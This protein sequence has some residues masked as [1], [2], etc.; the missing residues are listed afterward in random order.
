MEISDSQATSIALSFLLKIRFDSVFLVTLVILK[1]S[2]R[3]EMC[4]A[5]NI[6]KSNHVKSSSNIMHVHTLQIEA[7]ITELK[8][9]QLNLANTERPTMAFLESIMKVSSRSIKLVSVKMN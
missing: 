1:G 8:A 9:L 6:L 7:V 5:Q 3:G 2:I 4:L